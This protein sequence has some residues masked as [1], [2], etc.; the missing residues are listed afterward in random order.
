MFPN[1]MGCF[2]TTELCH[3][4]LH[5]EQ[6]CHTPGCFCRYRFVSDAA[7]RAADRLPG[8][9]ERGVEEGEKRDTRDWGGGIGE[10]DGGMGARSMLFLPPAVCPIRAVIRGCASFTIVAAV[11]VVCLHGFACVAVT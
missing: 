5:R 1:W 7:A 2:R 6:T 4:T 10:C 8:K 9:K 11:G 3:G